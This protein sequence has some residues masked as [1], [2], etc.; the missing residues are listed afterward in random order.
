MEE[1]VKLINVVI[2]YLISLIPPIHS[3]DRFPSEDVR[4]LIL[5]LPQID[6]KFLKLTWGTVVIPSKSLTIKKIF[7]NTEFKVIYLTKSGIT[8]RNIFDAVMEFKN[9]YHNSIAYSGLK[10]EEFTKEHSIL[11]IE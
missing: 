2:Y 10:L 5:A 6:S 11:S 9:Y 3:T 7:M 4:E 1:V 8:L